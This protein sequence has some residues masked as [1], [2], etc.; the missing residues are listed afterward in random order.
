M[1]KLINITDYCDDLN[2]YA[3][4]SELAAMTAQFGLDGLEVMPSGIPPVYPFLPGQVIGVHMC[5]QS[6]WLDL[7]QDN[8][9]ALNREYGSPET[10]ASVFGGTSRD[11]LLQRARE[12][13]AYAQQCGASYVVFHI[14][15]VRPTDILT[16]QFSYRDKDVI[17][18]AAELINLLLDGIEPS[19]EFLAENLWWPGMRLTDVSLTRLLLDSIRY[20]KKGIMLDLGH[21][22]HTKN[23]LR[24]QT[25]AVSYIRA[26]LKEHQSIHSMI[27]GVH[28]HQ[29]LTGVYVEQF[30]K[31]HRSL[32]ESYQERYSLAMQ[33]VIEIDRHDPFTDPGIKTLI[34]DIAPE[35]LTLE[36]LS[37]NRAEHES[38]IRAQLLALQTSDIVFT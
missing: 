24:T 19:F 5:C 9:D 31:Q 28:L 12:D 10:W 26:M 7:W 15:N 20:P 27:R 11:I 16:H 38:K 25:E 2:R 34:Q 21:F 35:Y 18:A 3:D 17:T 32:P 36:F 23:S 30:L 37:Q 6:D 14:A 1:K 29:S 33:H 4:A 8:K 13:L 22:L